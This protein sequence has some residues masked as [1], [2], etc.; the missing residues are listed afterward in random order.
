MGSIKIPRVL[1]VLGVIFVAVYVKL[2]LD[3]THFKLA[4]LYPYALLWTGYRDENLAAWLKYA[5]VNRDIVFHPSPVPE[6][7]AKGKLYI[8]Q[9]MVKVSRYCMKCRFYL[10]ELSSCHPQLPLSCSG[11]WS[12]R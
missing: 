11:A 10:R 7:Q 2:Q 8:G 3:L 12:I 6:I 4:W 1:F 5:P 9:F